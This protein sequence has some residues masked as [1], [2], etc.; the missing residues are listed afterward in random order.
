[1]NGERNGC[2]KMKIKC[3]KC[4]YEDRMEN[5]HALFYMSEMPKSSGKE[6]QQNIYMACPKCGDYDFC[7]HFAYPF[8]SKIEMSASHLVA[9]PA[10]CTTFK[11]ALE[12]ANN[13]LKNY[14]SI[15]DI[16]IKFN[17]EMKKYSDKLSKKE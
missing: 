7:Q 5:F 4:G 13:A 14:A 2:D 15:D 17:D 3:E 11:E 12:W 9:P 1:M 16:A 8:S 6:Y 10:S